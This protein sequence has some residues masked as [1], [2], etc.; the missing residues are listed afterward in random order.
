MI[1]TRWRGARSA[2][3]GRC[4]A[5]AAAA[6]LAAVTR[7]RDAGGADAHASTDQETIPLLRRYTDVGR[8][9]WRSAA[10]ASATRCCRATRT[11]PPPRPGIIPYFCDRPCLDLHG[12]TDAADRA[13]AGRSERS[14]P[15]GTRALAA[16]LRRRFASAAS[17]SCSSGPIRTST[18]APWRRRRTT[19]TSWSASSSPDGRFV[20]FTLLNPALRARAERDPRL[21]FYDPPTPSPTAQHF[22]ARASAS[23]AGASS[24]ALDWGD[25]DSEVAHAF[26]EHRSP[27]ERRTSTAGTPSCSATWRRSTPCGSRTT[28]GASTAGRSGRSTT[29]LPARDLVLI[30][31]TDH[32]GGGQLRRR[33]ERPARRDAAADPVAA[34]RMVGR[35][36]ADA[37]RARCCCR[38]GID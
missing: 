12:L 22:H 19:A 15:H 36:D 16:G 6:L 37:F 20:D 29:W 4:G 9:D 25:G 10:A 30:A 27:P 24:I 21:V 38:D 35:R 28:D 3:D 2:R 14:R 34:R 17:T 13:R 18:R 7:P 33:G 1:G 5:A 31:R 8:F 26:S 11:S 32:T 23:P